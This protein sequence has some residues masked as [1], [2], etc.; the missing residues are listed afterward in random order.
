MAANILARRL[1]VSRAE[2]GS[3]PSPELL[4]EATREIV[5]RYALRGETASPVHGHSITNQLR[6]ELSPIWTGLSKTAHNDWGRPEERELDREPDDHD[7]RY[8]E[9]RRSLT[10]LEVVGDVQHVG[11]A[12]W[13]PAPIRL[14]RLADETDAMVLLI[15]GAPLQQ[16]R[17]DG[18]AGADVCGGVRAVRL[19]V[20]PEAVRRDDSVWQDIDDWLRSPTEPIELWGKRLLRYAG[21]NLVQS[22]AE[23]GPFEIYDPEGHRGE[24]QYFRWTEARAYRARSE[25]LCLCRTVSQSAGPR[26]YW[27]GNLANGESGA[28]S[29]RE[30]PLI[31]EDIRRLQYALDA[32]ANTPTRGS[33]T[34]RT[35]SVDLAVPNYLPQSESRLLTALA[36][37]CSEQPGRLPLVY[38]VKSAMSATVLNRIAAL[39]VQW[40]RQTR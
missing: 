36:E 7:R 8:S 37:D 9:L 29:V 18:Y 11:A 31:G 2:L 32:L 22:H 39:G 12:Y 10:N 3:G 33:V 15:G 38:R 24:P 35:D 25:H 28:R 6:R 34:Y 21:A 26:R 17:L 5:F 16:L 19:S 23:I 40:T 30:C 4:A 14:L 1:G 27:I 13:L 20:L